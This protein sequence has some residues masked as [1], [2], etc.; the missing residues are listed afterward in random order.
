MGNDCNI[1]TDSR[2][3]QSSKAKK[4]SLT[5]IRSDTTIIPIALFNC[6]FRTIL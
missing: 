4:L 2:D 3:L 5:E 1:I 6:K